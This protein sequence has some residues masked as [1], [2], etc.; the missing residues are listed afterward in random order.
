[1]AKFTDMTSKEVFA[2]LNNFA[3]T[4]V[5]GANY[6]DEHLAKRIY[7]ASPFFT[8]KSAAVCD[9]AFDVAE[10]YNRKV[11][12]PH[13]HQYSSPQEMYDANI[14]NIKLADEVIA[15]IGEK[16]CGTSFEIGY[17]KALGKK[18]TLL[19]FTLDDIYQSKTNLMLAIDCGIIS[20]KRLQEYLA[21]AC[22]KINYIDSDMWDYIE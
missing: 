2:V 14:N 1:M 22:Y 3:D 12:F 16:D 19:A 7:F 9:Y 17:A 21:G 5:K 6:D 15:F 13:K 18:V 11:Y 10:K 8:D 4:L 20:M